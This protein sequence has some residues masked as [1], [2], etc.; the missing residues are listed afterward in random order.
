ME[1]V[2]AKDP[3]LTLTPAAA[4]QVKS[5]LATDPA[6]AGKTLRVFVEG[7]GCSGMKYGMVFDEQRP[8]DRIA[9]QD[10]VNVLVD[11]VSADY[12]RGTQIDFKDDLNESGFKITNPNA[13][14]SCGCGKSFDA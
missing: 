8:D 4:A 1:S 5:L 13:R 6:H 3:I 2:T 11:P 14:Q 10:G 12:L 7:G 9:E